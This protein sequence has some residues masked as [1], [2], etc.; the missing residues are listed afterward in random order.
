[1]STFSEP[2]LCVIRQW[3]EA[4]LLERA[5]KDIRLKYSELLKYAFQ[6]VQYKHKALSCT[7]LY[8]SRDGSES[9]FGIG[10][11]QWPKDNWDCPSGFYVEDIQLENLTSSRT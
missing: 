9:Y 5:M 1:M 3:H 6:K 10:K 4:R 11:D 7:T 8:L 2:E